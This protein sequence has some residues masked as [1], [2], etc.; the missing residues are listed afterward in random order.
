MANTIA[1]LL[2]LAAEFPASAF[3]Q[4]TLVNRRP[5]LA[6]DAATD[7]ACQWTLAAHQALGSTLTLAVKYF[8]ASGNTGTIDFEVDVEAITDG[9]AQVLTADSF[10]A[11]NGITAEA[12]PG[13]A[14]YMGSSSSR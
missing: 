5:V 9:D 1:V 14:G 11:L 6:F 12:V 8:M 4:L 10:D 2:P 3:A 13:T 7:E